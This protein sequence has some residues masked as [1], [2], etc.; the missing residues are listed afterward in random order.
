MCLTG[1]YGHIVSTLGFLKSCWD[2]KSFARGGPALT[3]FFCFVFMEG[4]R[5]QIPLKAGHH[6]PASE[7][8]WRFAGG[9]I[10][11]PLKWRFAGGSMMAQHR[12]LAW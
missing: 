11:T 2:S 8:P 1:S 4:G 12:M 6:L 10:M 3:T 9:P 7:T 5:I